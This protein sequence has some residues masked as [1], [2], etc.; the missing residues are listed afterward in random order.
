MSDR[1]VRRHA[2]PRVV[3]HLDH[4]SSPIDG[5]RPARHAGAP[6]FAFVVREPLN[7]HP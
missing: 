5:E 2:K 3:T 7:T 6:E 4:R 1:T